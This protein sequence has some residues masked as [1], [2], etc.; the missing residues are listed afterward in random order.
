MSYLCLQVS[1]SAE[2]VHL[3]GHFSLPNVL[4]Q[5]EASLM[6]VRYTIVNEIR[7]WCLSIWFV[8]KSGKSADLNLNFAM[9]AALA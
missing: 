5:L 4:V 7:G 6:E 3:S 2:L 8:N 9:D 1:T